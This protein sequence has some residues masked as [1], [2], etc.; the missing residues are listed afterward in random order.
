MKKNVR[1]QIEELAD[2]IRMESATKDIS[3]LKKQARALYEKLVIIEYLELQLNEGQIA[4]FEES[5]DSKSYREQNWFTDPQPVPEPEN[6]E[7]I[8]E[9]AIEKIKDIV[10]QMPRESEEVESILEEILPKKVFEKND[11]DELSSHYKDIPVFER[12]ETASTPNAPA[13]K[14]LEA[15][16]PKS[17]NDA[18]NVGLNIGLNDR[19]AYIKHLF[20]GSADDFARVVSQINTFETLKEAEQFIEEQVKPDYGHWK[21][22]L[23]YAERFLAHLEKRFS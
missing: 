12:K 3:S 11:W 4:S 2:K 21:E 10:A 18:L 9:P 15:E 23:E 6:K 16:R 17:L 5:L 1:K 20:D 7:E 22:K 8:V 14:N 19:L 13:T